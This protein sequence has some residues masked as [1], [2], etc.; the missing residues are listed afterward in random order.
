LGPTLQ[1]SD[2][3]NVSQRSVGGRCGRQ[4]YIPKHCRSTSLRKY[5]ARLCEQI[6]TCLEQ[7]TVPGSNVVIYIYIDKP[8]VAEH[9]PPLPTS[10]VQPLWLN[11]LLLTHKNYSITSFL[12]KF[13]TSIHY[14]SIGLPM[15]CQS[16]CASGRF[17]GW[18]P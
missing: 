13:P 1:I 8:N 5:G 17:N 15:T 6:V 4:Q 16:E 11:C 7:R 9:R 3:N 2:T 18:H 12:I 10:A 14:Q